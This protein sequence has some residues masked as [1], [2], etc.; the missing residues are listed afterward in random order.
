MVKGK[1]VSVPAMK[2]YWGGGGVEASLMLVSFT[3]RP[4]YHL[5]KSHLYLINRCQGRHQ[6]QCRCFGEKL[7]PL[8]GTEQVCSLDT[9]STEKHI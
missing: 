5:K 1:V 7:S 4:F 9:I 2:S 8:S 3:P 6:N